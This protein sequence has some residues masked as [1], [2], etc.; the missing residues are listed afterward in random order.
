[1]QHYPPWSLHWPFHPR[2]RR[3]NLNATILANGTIEANSVVVNNIGQLF[4]DKSLRSAV[5]VT[6]PYNTNRQAIVLGNDNWRA[7]SAASAGYDPSI[8][9]V[10]L[11]NEITDR[12]FL[13]FYRPQFHRWLHWSCIRRLILERWGRRGQ[14]GWD[15]LYRYG[16]VD[17]ECA[18][19]NNC[20][21]IVNR[22]ISRMKSNKKEPELERHNNS[23]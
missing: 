7:P 23:E 12:L 8:K 22:L 14:W 15:H 13:E 19:T 17:L 11:G 1:M 18:N 16:T 5:E 6:Y 21:P 4:F 9:Y 20:I 2:A 10:L 3:D